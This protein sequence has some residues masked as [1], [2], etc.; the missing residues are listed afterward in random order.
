VAHDVDAGSRV[1]L[2]KLAS[3][4]FARISNNTGRPEMLFLFESSKLEIHFLVMVQTAF[5]Q[6]GRPVEEQEGDSKR[7]VSNCGYGHRQLA[8]LHA[9]RSLRTLPS[10]ESTF[11]PSAVSPQPQRNC[12]LP[13]LNAPSPLKALRER[14]IGHLL[15]V[16]C[17]FS[18]RSLRL[19]RLTLEVLLLACCR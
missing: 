8:F 4:E 10:S 17:R 7:R 13:L 6:R 2:A 18:R 9:S 16:Q 5:E 15:L 11:Y 1:S 12:T 19:S 3:P 14:S